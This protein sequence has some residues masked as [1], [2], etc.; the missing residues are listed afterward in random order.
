M[1]NNKL[2]IQL[3]DGTT[4]WVPVN[5]NR[6]GNNQYMIL[7]DNE[8]T[9]YTHPLYLHE[10]YPG[11]VVESGIQTQQDGT[12][13]EI[14]QKLINEGQWTDRKFN[15]FKFKATL[16]QLPI[17]KMTA[18]CYQNEINRVKNEYADGQFFY[19]SLMNTVE[20]LARILVNE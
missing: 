5:V 2:Y 3:L 13:I 19:P 9:D 7:E 16:G 14:A 17:N 20:K 6:I 8:Y 10:F 12:T 15:V 4:I 1:I 18:D 11:D